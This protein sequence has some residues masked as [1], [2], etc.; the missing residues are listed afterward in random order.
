MRSEREKLLLP[1]A[2]LELP[3]VGGLTGEG[4]AMDL[5]EGG[6]PLH[7][8]P[9][10]EEEEEVD[11]PVGVEPQELANGL[12]GEDLGVGELRGGSALTDTPSFELIV[13]QAEDGYDEGAK[14]HAKTSAA[15]GAI[16]ST[17][18]R[19]GRSSIWLKSSKKLAHGVS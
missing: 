5:A 6:E 9:A 7:V 13:Y 12:D 8:V 18:P 16:E 3:G 14:I 1:E 2:L 19:V 17:T 15:P 11:V 10:E 4:G